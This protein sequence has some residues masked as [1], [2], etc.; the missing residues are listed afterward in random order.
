MS[1]WVAAVYCTVLYK[2]VIAHG[3][4]RAGIYTSMCQE[5]APQPAETRLMPRCVEHN[6]IIAIM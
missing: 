3:Y 5:M 1:G 6:A 2:D 4:N